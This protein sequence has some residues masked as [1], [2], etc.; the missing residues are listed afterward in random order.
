MNNL[1][2]SRVEGIDDPKGGKVYRV[3][4]GQF[5][6]LRQAD[7]FISEN[8]LKKLFS[9]RWVNAVRVDHSDVRPDQNVRKPGDPEPKESEVSDPYQL[10]AQLNCE[11][12]RQGE[13][14]AQFKPD[15]EVKGSEVIVKVQWECT[16]K[17]PLA[18]SENKKTDE[19]KPVEKGPQEGLP[20]YFALSGIGG[21][22]SVSANHP[23]LGNVSPAGIVYGGE[24]S[25]YSNLWHGIGPVLDYRFVA[26]RTQ[27]AGAYQTS[28]DQRLNA[29]V[30]L[31]L[32]RFFD[33]QPVLGF[34]SQNFIADDGAGTQVFNTLY[35]PQF[36]LNVRLNILRPRE[37]VSIDLMGKANY[38]IPLVL[39]AGEVTSGFQF[40]GALR[41][42]MIY[43]KSFGGDWFLEY[44][45]RM[46]SHTS[47]WQTES[48][49]IGGLTIL[50]SP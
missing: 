15:P 17:N 29:G 27:L 28:F 16:I 9:E 14:K 1:S 3:L 32:G 49:F 23:T 5:R 33:F 48:N 24:F 50:L 42:R 21:Y 39:G 10:T 41:T 18:P 30:N 19:P 38:L 4:V 22:A 8:R 45:Y 25:A 13:Y 37:G 7:G 44:T 35:I 40:G 11:G 34:F 2:P 6:S 20:S 46:Q 36:G 12:T 43:P 31:P 26:R 47:V